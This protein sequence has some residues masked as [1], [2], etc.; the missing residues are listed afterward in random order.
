M[1][2]WNG[3]GILQCHQ[4]ICEQDNVIVDPPQRNIISIILCFSPKHTQENN[5]Q[6]KKCISMQNISEYTIFSCTTISIASSSIS[7]RPPQNFLT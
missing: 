1:Q 5:I 6:D 2:T 3:L 4:R 7:L